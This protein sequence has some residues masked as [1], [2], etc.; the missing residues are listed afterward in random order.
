MRPGLP[1]PASSEP[2]LLAHQEPFTG[3][4][5]AM[6]GTMGA[7][8]DWGTEIPHAMEKLSPHPATREFMHHKESAKTILGAT[9]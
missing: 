4:S 7:I 2:Y 1:F 3:T 6:Q 9:N 5:L 8:P